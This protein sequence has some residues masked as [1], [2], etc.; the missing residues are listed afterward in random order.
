MPIYEYQCP[1]GIINET[2]QFEG[3]WPEPVFINHI[4]K[5]AE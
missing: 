2:V 3:A 5:A 1:K 4:L